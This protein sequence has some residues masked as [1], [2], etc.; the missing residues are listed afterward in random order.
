LILGQTILTKKKK[1]R[2]MQSLQIISGYHMVD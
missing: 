2:L 1:V